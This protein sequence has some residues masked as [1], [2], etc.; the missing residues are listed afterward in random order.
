MKKQRL[1]SVVIPCFNEEAVLRE[2]HLRVSMMGQRLDDL[3][4]E[5]IYV[6]DG[7]R[8]RTPQ[9]LDALQ[10]TD[11]HVRVIQLSRNFGHQIAVTAGL[12]HAAGDAVVLIDADLQDPPELI[13]EMVAKWCSGYD[14]VYAERLSREG[15]TRF[16]LATARAFY[17]ILNRIADTE[18]P[19]DTGDFRLI[20]RRVVEALREMPEHYRFVRGLVSWA[21]FRQIAVPYHRVSRYAGES[22]YPLAKMLRFAFDGI[23]SFSVAPLR[24]VT[25]IGFIAS[26]LATVGIIYALGM[27]LFTSNWVT[28]WTA[29]FIGIL[30]IGGVQ[31]LSLGIIGEY[32]GRIYGEAKRRPLYIVRERLGFEP[33]P[34]WPHERADGLDGRVERQSDGTLRLRH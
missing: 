26:L 30:F 25:G 23:T 21:G 6:D 19:P 3:D 10:C 17:R 24:M 8:D 12:E 15:E 34:A 2:L 14:V 22:K 1:L 13:P 20:D 7:S 16:K 29:L 28:G 4:Y 11:S 18:I 27:R 33:R 31:L 9:I 5:I 32:I